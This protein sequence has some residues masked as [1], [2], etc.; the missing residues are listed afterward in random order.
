MGRC[1]AMHVGL[2]FRVNVIVKVNVA[3]NVNVGLI[4]NADYCKC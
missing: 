1:I 3:G 2:H 4:L